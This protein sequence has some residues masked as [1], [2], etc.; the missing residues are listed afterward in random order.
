MIKNLRYLF[1][2]LLAIFSLNASAGSIVFADLELENGTKYSSFDGGD[3]T[4]TFGGG[5]NDGKYYDAGTGIRVYGGGSM[6]IAA[7]EG[8]IKKI[9]ITYDGTYKPDDASVVSVGT[10]DVAGGY[11]TGDAAEVTFTR[12]SGS[13]HW[14]VKS[15]AVNDA[16][17]IGR[18]HV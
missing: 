14:R 3:F 8:T 12:P 16:A 15:I 7:K 10:Y 18:A 5:G 11:W 13:G 1:V 17:E 9:V 4:V 2:A 6:T